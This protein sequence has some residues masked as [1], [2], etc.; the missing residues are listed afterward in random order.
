[1]TNEI[2]M[3]K[4]DT[5]EGSESLSGFITGI[6]DILNGGLGLGL[7]LVFFLISYYKLSEHGALPAFTAASFSTAVIGFLLAAEKIVPA[8]I[9]F[10]VFIASSSGIVYMWIKQRY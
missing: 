9:P 8:E 3:G 6:N 2:E 4:L 5:I 1:M 10:L 7:L